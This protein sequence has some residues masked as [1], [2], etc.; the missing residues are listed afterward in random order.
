MKK[1]HFLEGVATLTGTIIGA[2][3]LGIPYVVHRAGFWTGML[4]IVVI[5]LAMLVVN[6]YLG[7][8]ALRTKGNH[9]LTGYASKYLGKWGKLLMSASMILGIYGALIAYMMGEGEALKAIFGIPEIAASLIFFAIAS[10]LIFFGLKVLEN[11]ELF[12][13]SLLLLVVAAICAIGFDRISAANL[14][15]FSISN[16]FI[17]YGVV[18]FAFLG[19]SAIPSVKEELARN[20][21]AIKKSIL[22]G[23]LIPIAVYLLFA[24]V[25]VGIVGNGFGSLA[26][27]QRLATVALSFFVGEKTGIF[28]NLFA[29]FSMMTSFVALGFAL[30]EMFCYDYK[31][32]IHR[33]WLLTCIIPLVFFLLDVFVVNLA[34]FITVLG[35][36]GALSGGIAGI[37]IVLMHHRA[38]KLGER[39]PEYSVNGSGL[40]S[41]ALAVM[42]IIGIILETMAIFGALSF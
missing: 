4:D 42:F 30:K 16:M 25:V 1:R 6:L 24:L 17:P 13:V 33:A 35:V 18:I 23:S 31:I 14:T 32:K 5:G 41:I 28:A 27:N 26:P 36:T 10:M 29:V 38:K 37:L 8:V 7:E 20:K 15:G 22:I 21:A 39:K 9:Q 11:C 19:T 40:I 12:M 34:S 3:V 2:G